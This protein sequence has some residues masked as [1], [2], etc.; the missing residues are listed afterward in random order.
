MA[1]GLLII[2]DE[3]L[4]GKRT[5]QHLQK[6]ISLLN[7]RGLQLAWA[8]IIGDDR[9]RITATLRRS[10]ASGDSVF[11]CGGIGATPDDHTRQCAAAALDVALAL[12]PEAKLKIEERIAEVALNDG[13]SAD[14]TRPDNLHRLK[15]GEF[16]VGAAIVPNPFNKIPGFSIRNH[17]FLP[18]FPEMAGPMMAWVL[19]TYFADS[20]HQNA[21]LERACLVYE[22]AESLLTPLMEQIEHDFPQVNVFS[23][24]NVGN[25]NTRRHIE[26]GVKG[27]ALMVPAAFERLTTGLD[28]LHAEYTLL[29]TA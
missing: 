29:V 6:L 7:E 16:P 12:H 21:R 18:G 19:N 3:I 25:A 4:S 9:S 15:M 11:C 5:D 26:L 22:L 14:L 1:I 10:F 23:L 2:G 8:E 27:D 20:F 13:K 24:P 28:Q 17:Y